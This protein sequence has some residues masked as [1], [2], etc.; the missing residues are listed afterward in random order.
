MAENKTTTPALM[1]HVISVGLTVASESVM[2]VWRDLF[3]DAA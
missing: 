1:T 2:F 3:D